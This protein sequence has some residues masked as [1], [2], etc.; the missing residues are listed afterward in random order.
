M[1]SWKVIL[2]EWLD[3]SWK[4][5]LVKWLHKLNPNSEIVN[6]WVSERYRDKQIIFS[7]YP[8]E[9]ISFFIE[10]CLEVD[11]I[12]KWII[13]EWK[14]VFLE[15]S[16]ATSLAY[17]WTLWL[18]IDEIKSKVDLFLQPDFC[19]FVDCSFKERKNRLDSRLNLSENDLDIKNNPLKQREIFRWYID[20][21]NLLKWHYYL[22]LTNN[23]GIRDSLEGIQRIIK[24]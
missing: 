10:V 21:F 23:I 4:T 19:F 22:L 16:I 3:W 13:K 15:R 12:V 24:K 5:T 1:K 6:F 8:D 20:W 7:N 14:N 18:N 17:S 2:F 11:D 9:I